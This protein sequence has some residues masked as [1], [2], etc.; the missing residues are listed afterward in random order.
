MLSHVLHKNPKDNDLRVSHELLNTERI[1]KIFQIFADIY[2]FLNVTGSDS[3]NTY[4][5]HYE[6]FY[7]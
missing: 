1:L 6:L 7:V 4:N 2:D 5:M 3:L